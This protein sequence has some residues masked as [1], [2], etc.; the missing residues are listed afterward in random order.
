VKYK[1][2]LKQRE[3]MAIN[4]MISND[5]NKIVIIITVVITTYIMEVMGIKI[6][7]IINKKVKVKLSP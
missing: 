1:E 7:I 3:N 4:A 6:I 2:T 5:S